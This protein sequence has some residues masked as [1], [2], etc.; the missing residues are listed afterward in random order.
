VL[1]N[2]V[3]NAIKY[4]SSGG[5]VTIEA[6]R[7]EQ[8]GIIVVTDTGEGI[9]REESSKIWDRLYRGD[10]S[11]S[12]RGLGLGLSLV[13]AVVQAHRGHVEVLSEPGKGSTFTVCLPFPSDEMAHAASS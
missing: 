12:Q 13:K 1:G 5:T 6:F 11:R 3:D 7:R 8:E 4:T 10:Q 2:L 9:S